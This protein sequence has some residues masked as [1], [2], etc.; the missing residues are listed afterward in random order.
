MIGLNIALS[1]PNL[2]GARCST[3]GG[4]GVDLSQWCT[5]NKTDFL[6]VVGGYL[7]NGMSTFPG[8]A[9][10]SLYGAWDYFE[11]KIT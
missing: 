9:H 6:K 1:M 11:I 5:E 4:N 10:I 8:G 2:S 7:P 3:K